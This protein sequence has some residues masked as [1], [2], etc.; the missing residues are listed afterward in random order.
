MAVLPIVIAPDPV[1]KTKAV[2]VDGV[3]DRIRTLL[4]DMLETMYDADG[5][6]LAAPQIGLSERIIVVDVRKGEERDEKDPIKMVNPEIIA[7]GQDRVTGEEGC[8]SIP[9]V[10][11]DVERWDD[12]TCQYLDENG[13]KQLIE[14]SGLLAICI[15]HEIDHLDGVLFTDH[16]SSLKRNMAMR[17]LKK[18]RREHDMA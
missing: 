9:S 11:G 15:Q 18:W 16:L 17:K 6:G 10:R 4:D 13:D 14:A 3:D 5:I 1:L 2:A 7:T 8:L 12:L